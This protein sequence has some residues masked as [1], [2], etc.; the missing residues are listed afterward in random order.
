MFPC[1]I[2]N[3]VLFLCRSTDSEDETTQ[4]HCQRDRGHFNILRLQCQSSHVN[5]S[6]MVSINNLRSMKQHIIVNIWIF[7]SQRNW[8]AYFTILIICVTVL[9]KQKTSVPYYFKQMKY[10]KQSYTKNWK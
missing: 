3:N 7:E 8:Q 5:E 10:S 9:K 2:E 1:H 4:Y 6:N